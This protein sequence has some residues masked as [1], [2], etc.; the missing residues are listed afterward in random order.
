MPITDESEQI[1]YRLIDLFDRTKPW[2]TMVHGFSHNNQ[3]FSTQASRFQQSHRL[4][5]P[6]LR[7]H[8]KSSELGGPF[9]IEEYTDDLLAAINQAGIEKTILWGTHTGAAVGLVLALRCPE[10]ISALILEGTYLPGFDMPRVDLLLA[11]AKK[12]ARLE[13]IQAALDDWFAYADWF[14][15]IRNHP[16]QTRET[17]HKNMVMCFQGEPWLSL[18]QPREITAVSDSLSNIKLPVLIYNGEYDMPDFISAAAKLARDLPNCQRIMIPN[19]GGFPAWEN[20]QFV[21][22]HVYKF[23]F[24]MNKPQMKFK[25]QLIKKT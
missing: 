23:L 18:D 12:I 1:F 14:D 20:P 17:E 13:G 10:K 5:L 4:L 25:C 6:D 19:A 8:G 24:S 9:G 22:K 7:G 2:I 11:R 21:N 15:Y 3:Y 16:A